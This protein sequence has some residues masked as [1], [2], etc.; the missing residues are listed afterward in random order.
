M[1][2]P[3]LAS[4]LLTQQQVVDLSGV[5]T[6]TF[7]H[8]KQV[9]NKKILFKK[10]KKKEETSSFFFKK[11]RIACCLCVII[12]IVPNRLTQNLKF[13]VK[14]EFSWLFFLFLTIFKN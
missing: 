8:R 14:K 2:S 7:S 4:A 3:T 9:H 11:I 5:W 6:G 1:G 10:R 13:T 12:F